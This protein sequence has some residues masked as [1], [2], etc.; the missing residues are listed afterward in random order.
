[1]KRIRKKAATEAVGRTISGGREVMT[2]ILARDKRN[3]RLLS[4]RSGPGGGGGG[5]KNL[6]PER[7]NCLGSL[8]LEGRPQR[9]RSFSAEPAGLRGQ[10]SMTS[11]PE[12][13]EFRRFF[14]LTENTVG[15]HARQIALAHGAAQRMA[16]HQCR[17]WNPAQRV[18]PSSRGPK[19]LRAGRRS[20]LDRL[21]PRSDGPLK[22]R[23]SRKTLSFSR[24]KTARLWYAHLD[25][26][27][28]GGILHG[29]S[30]S[31]S[32][33]E[34]SLEANCARSLEARPLHTKTGACQ[35]PRAGAG[36]AA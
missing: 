8:R 29:K 2:E 9:F 17:V 33:C 22:P 16:I 4:R 36:G 10:P 18:A 28:N 6:I 5:A 1:M 30:S 24:S 14:Q 34:G 25:G 32:N 15:C 35:N 19:H 27:A 26:K 3:F 7:V 11:R 20:P 31:D 23:T 12:G 13:G 21:G